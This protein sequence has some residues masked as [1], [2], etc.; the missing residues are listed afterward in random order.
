[1]RKWRECSQKPHVSVG[2]HELED[3]LLGLYQAKRGWWRCFKA[4]NG[5]ALCF[6]VDVDLLFGSTLK[7][8]LK[9]DISLCFIIITIN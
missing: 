5:E 7:I 4:G 2:L 9:F 8:A 6:G 3:V 1:L